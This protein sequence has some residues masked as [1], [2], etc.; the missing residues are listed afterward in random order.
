MKDLFKKGTMQNFMKSAHEIAE[1]GERNVSDIEVE[2]AFLNSTYMYGGNI[3]MLKD[4]YLD[5]KMYQRA[6]TVN[7]KTVA[8]ICNI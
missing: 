8:S 3:L 6:E 7:M 1:K 2:L 5:I 4:V